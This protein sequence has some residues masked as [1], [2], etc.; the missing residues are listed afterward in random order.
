[1]RAVRVDVRGADHRVRGGPRAAARGPA[2]SR[3]TLRGWGAMRRRSSVTL[4]TGAVF[5]GLVVLL[6]LVSLFWLPYDS[7]DTSGGR[8]AGPGGGHLLGT[9]KLGRDLFTQLMTGSRIE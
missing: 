2:P 5:A 4:W 3:A 8:L 7:E 9:D 1:G 6:A